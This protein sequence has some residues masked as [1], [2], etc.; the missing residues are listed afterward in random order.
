[1]FFFLRVFVY[2]GKSVGL[3]I[4]YFFQR[5]ISLL[6]L[7]RFFFFFS[8]LVYLFLLAKLGLFPFFYWVVVVRVKVG[9]VANMFVLRL[10][11]V[12]LFWLIWLVMEC[13]LR[14]LYFLVYLRVFFVVVNLLF[15]RDLW[16]LIVYSSIANSGIILLRVVG[17]HYIRMMILYLC[18]IFRVIYFI[19][20]LDSYVELVVLVFFFLV[21]PPFVLFM[22][23]LYLVVR[24]DS[25][26]KLAMYFVIFDVLVLFYYF[27]LVFM[28]F[29]LMEVRILIYIMNL[30][31]LVLIIVLR[32]CVAMIVFY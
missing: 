26:V 25:L 1:M 17:S 2:E 4:Y 32:N 8:K 3:V 14:M 16:L 24:L 22:I 31:I 23:K 10:Q 20:K 18:V 19:Y 12:V 29:M 28:K 11:K 6:L 30:M 15:V 9:V 21:V 5:C 7:I 27:R 13:S